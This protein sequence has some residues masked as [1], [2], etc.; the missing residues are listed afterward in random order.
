MKKT[1]INK[2]PIC[3]GTV[4]IAAYARVWLSVD[5][6]GSLDLCTEAKDIIKDAVSTLENRDSLWVKK[7]ED[8]DFDV[9]Y[10]KS[11]LELPYEV[12]C[13][14]CEYDE[15]QINRLPNGDFEISADV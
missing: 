1:A 14:D 2:C 7:R 4:S 3:G 13:D 11:E 6:D 9:S 8:G 5:E 10:G 12:I 15:F